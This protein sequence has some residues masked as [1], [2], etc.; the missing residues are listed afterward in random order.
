MQL[1]DWVAKQ[2]N[3]SVNQKFESELNVQR[4]SVDSEV[5]QAEWQAQIL[6]Q[7][8]PLPGEIN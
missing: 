5:L 2:Y 1:G 4:C 8:K 6:A 7:T 3:K